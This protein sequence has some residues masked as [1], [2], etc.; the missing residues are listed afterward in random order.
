VGAGER[1]ASFELF[2]ETLEPAWIAQALTATGT[3][4]IRRRKLPAEYVVWLVIGM[5]LL[6]DRSIREVVRHLD[7]VLPTGARRETVSG[8]AI[9]QA[10]AR[11][12][13][14]PL[15]ALFAQSA[16]VWGPAA[17]D[18]ERWRGLAVYG[19]DG[20]TL[21]VPD[22]A[23]NDAAFGRV[24]TRWDSTGGYPLLR[25]VALMVLRRHVLTGLA[26]GAYRDSELALATTL[27]PQLPDA[28]LVIVDRE[29]ATYALF[30]QLA[31]PARQRHWLSR[32]KSGRNALR[33]R[34]IERLG[35]G[36]HLV[37]LCPSHQT[38]FVHRDLPPTLRVRAIRYH[39]RG[40]RPQTLLTSL[41]DPVAYPAAEL[42]ALYHERWELELGFDEVKTHT[43]EREEALRSKT[44][45]RI[46]QEVWGLAL[47]Y[48]LVRLAMARVAARARVPPV[49]ISFRHALQFIRLFWLTAWTTS[50]GVLPRRLDALH[51][52]LALLILPERRPQ[53][54][55]PRVVKIKMSNYP[56]KRPRRRR[57]HVK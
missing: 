21:R 28:S 3:A 46:A 13:P 33:R 25:L 27:W 29:F 39:F 54:R 23:E 7:L 16:A 9:V 20:T 8:G 31:D 18:A 38:R 2:S 6:R 53:R 57:I 41:L 19:V 51:D 10:R 45:A 56:R 43:L 35:P 17:A 40:F 11:L 47:G 1:A 14:E 32:V 34:V 37:E 52:E 55:Y 26:L 24:P 15:A 49:R 42:V 30:H 44:P 12:G 36:D 4:S 5:G 22:T 48:N 50:P